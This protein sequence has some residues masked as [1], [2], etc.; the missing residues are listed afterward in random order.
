MADLDDDLG[1]EPLAPT[2]ATTSAPPAPDDDLGFEPIAASAPQPTKTADVAAPEEPSF[3]DKINPFGEGSLNPA[4]IAY[5][6]VS[7]SV[8]GEAPKTPAARAVKTY[9]QNLLAGAALGADTVPAAVQAAG[10]YTRDVLTGED[11]DFKKSMA[12]ARQSLA[13]GRK[14]FPLTAS[15][16]Q[17][18]GNIGTS[19]ATGGM[20]TAAVGTKL[21]A[22][23]TAAKLLGSTAGKIGV[24]GV[25]LLAEGAVEGGIQAAVQTVDKT[26]ENGDWQSLGEKLQVAV[27]AGALEGAKWNL[28]I[29]GA[30]K[31]GLGL[32]GKLGK[33]GKA[34]PDEE[35][36]FGNAAA[37]APPVGLE[38]VADP[39]LPLRSADLIDTGSAEAVAARQQTTPLVAKDVQADA[40]PELSKDLQ[41][42]ADLEDNHVKSLKFSAETAFN[43]LDVGNGGTPNLQ[44]KNVFDDKLPLRASEIVDNAPPDV[45][46]ARKA[47]TPEAAEKIQNKAL[48]TL[49]K[50]VNRRAEIEAALDHKLRLRQKTDYHKTF[51]QPWQGPSFDEVLAQNGLS[52]ITLEKLAADTVGDGGQVKRILRQIEIEKRN[53]P[54]GGSIE[55]PA[56]T[57]RGALG[58]LIEE[59]P[60][61]GSAGPTTGQ[62]IS[63]LDQIKRTAQKV[64]A[65]K[66]GLLHEA[67]LDP[68]ENLR[69]YLETPG[70]VPEVAARGQAAVNAAWSPDIDLQRQASDFFEDGRIKAEAVG[71]DPYEVIE[72]VKP[73]ALKS[74]LTTVGKEGV[75]ETAE[76]IFRARGRQ[77]INSF[78]ERLR[79]GGD[80]PGNRK[81]LAEYA[82]L[83]HEAEQELNRVALVNRYA[84]Q[85]AIAPTVDPALSALKAGDRVNGQALGGLL[86]G[87]GK[88]T[89]DSTE[90]G[91]KAS[92]RRQENALAPGPVRDEYRALRLKVEANLNRVALANK[93]A[94]QNAANPPSAVGAARQVA[95]GAFES[96]PVAGGAYKATKNIYAAWRATK[97]ADAAAASQG[98]KSAIV[99]A[100]QRLDKAV[101]IQQ[102]LD[103]AANV[104]EKAVEPAI[105]L[106]R[107]QKEIEKIDATQDPESEEYKKT[108]SRVDEVRQHGGEELAQAFASQ[109]DRRNQFLLDKAGPAPR[110]TVFGTEKRELD[111]ETAATLHRAMA[112]ADDPIG[113]IERLSNGTNSIEDVEALEQLYP[114]MLQEW[115]GKVIDELASSKKKPTAEQAE[116]LSSILGVGFLPDSGASDVAFYQGL[117]STG[118]DESNS[119]K[120][121]SRMYKGQS[122]A[123]KSRGDRLG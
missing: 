1:F 108:L 85:A 52:P 56:A 100:Q 68:T 12:E 39:N 106:D 14:E 55:L 90:E 92:L 10:D 72:V 89:F 25:G 95:E 122:D 119:G 41:R 120:A 6:F 63:A 7:S 105:V 30:A 107:V 75:D 31:T 49:E 21:L 65:K 34:L 54:N 35:L 61:R 88:P 11:S 87:I 79:W 83:T 19:L 50:N 70:A 59:A 37:E 28:I 18:A 118:A 44:T 47:I 74:L 94:A 17:V 77:R 113:A 91:L 53:L 112:A 64:A 40:F 33:S 114:S 109:I 66:G 110:T 103:T 82:K 16:A 102:R 8:T 111:E 121:N 99:K 38:D 73:G 81:L 69:R 9:G 80:E 22:T 15:G 3:L 32:L 42:L 84:A 116:I 20:G 45:V 4:R 24:A 27:P 43:D 36:K 97:A 67:L 76:E 78:G 48:S 13:A 62:M 5:D 23:S 57:R 86:D 60:K 93:Y 26:I 104:V 98:V 58:E 71:G 117:A 101:K 46:A 29:G 96:I 123:T 115:R 2:P 51:D